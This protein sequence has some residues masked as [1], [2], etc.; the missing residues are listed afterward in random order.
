[1]SLADIIT[2]AKQGYKPSDIKELIELSKS[3]EEGSPEKETV[4]EDS[5]GEDQYN[6]NQPIIKN[7]EK[8]NTTTDDPTEDEKIVDY[9]KKV[10]EL[11]KQIVDLQKKAAHEK[12][13]DTSPEKTSEEVFLEAAR[14]F[15]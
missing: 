8:S 7:E 10:E 1:M 15:M 12:I 11:E 2:L 13:A 6:S 3:S 9:K 5:K 14:K 4:N